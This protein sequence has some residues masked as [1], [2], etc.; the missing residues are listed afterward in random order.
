MILKQKI[1]IPSIETQEKVVEILDKFVK[2]N[3]E[4]QAELQNRSKQY[5][6]YRNLLLSEEYLNKLAENP[7]II[8]GGTQN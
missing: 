2:Y 5:E 1:A 6:Y 7:E 3:I 4:L 8:G